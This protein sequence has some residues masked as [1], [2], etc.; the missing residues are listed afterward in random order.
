MAVHIFERDENGNRVEKVT[1][2]GCVF[3]TRER[4]FYDD[5]DFYA[6][7]WDEASQD[8]IEVEYAT[9]RGW[10]YDN[11]ADVDATPE[12]CKK[13]HDALMP[14]VFSWL[15]S[16]A[17]QK[18][19]KVE[20]GKE[21]VVAKG[22]K[23]P[24]GARGFVFYVGPSIKYYQW[25]SASTKIGISASKQ[26]ENRKY[27]DAVWTYAENVQV[28][29]PEQYSPSDESLME[30]ANELSEDPSIILRKIRA[31]TGMVCM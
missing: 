4:N 3:E 2:E 11:H 28:L 21:V 9:T 27:P 20:V 19:N 12:V 24:V 10:T 6:V 25:G 15:K 26:L 29:N 8:V 1:Y 31:Y 18:A 16:D 5:S 14:K 22:R 17:I 7:V 13:A 23:A 30:K